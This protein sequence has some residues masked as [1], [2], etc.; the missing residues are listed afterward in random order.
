MNSCSVTGKKGINQSAQFFPE[1]CMRRTGRKIQSVVSIIF[2][3][4]SLSA[5][6]VF[7]E[8]D[9][10]Y[11]SRY[12]VGGGV[13][14]Q[15]MNNQPRWV[16]DSQ[17]MVVITASIRAY[18]GLSLQGGIDYSRGGKPDSDSLTWGDYHLKIN[19]G[20]F[21]SSKWAGIRY[22]LPLSV[23]GR[24]YLGIYSIYGAAGMTWAEYGVQSTQWT[25]KGVAE[26]DENERNFRVADLRGLYGV[27]AARWHIDTLGDNPEEDAALLGE[28]GVDLGVRFTRY[29][30]ST[31]R[32]SNIEKM[33]SNF[34]N[35]QIFLVGFLKFDLF[36]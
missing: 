30:E 16:T 5:A 13:G 35:Y 9:P 22:E 26:T 15:S 12:E 31:L 6:S 34:S 32:H 3:V 36:N 11:G 33:P 1:K 19:K 14:F 23:V 20:T 2:I 25:N 18:K 24:N 8:K 17:Q 10:V 29:N 27:L 28:Y 21:S 7:A 4:F